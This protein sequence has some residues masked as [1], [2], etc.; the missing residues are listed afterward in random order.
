[1]DRS[2]GTAEQ[3]FCFVLV[4]SSKQ[5]W[6]AA[7]TAKLS[8]LGLDNTFMGYTSM[9][10]DLLLEENAEINSTFFNLMLEA[11]LLKI[12]SKLINCRRNALV[13]N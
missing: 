12:Y 6:L 8:I 1:L 3:Y 4:N 5:N 9:Q 2:I 11:P 13:S 7:L 10:T